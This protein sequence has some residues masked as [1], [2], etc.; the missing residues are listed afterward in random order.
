[1]RRIALALVLLAAIGCRPPA[2]AQEPPTAVVVFD[3]S[4]SMWGKP[5]PGEPKAKFVLA[6]EA[7]RQAF[8]PV[9]AEARLGLLSFGH[10]RPG[11]CSDVETIVKAESGT[12]ERIGAALDKLNPKGR[13]PITAALREAAKELGPQSAQSSIILVHDD[14]DNCQADP[15]SVVGELRRAHPKVAVHVVSIGLKREDAQ[16]MQCLTKPTG[17]THHEVAS[18]Q[19]ATA[20]IEGVVKAALLDRVR[21]PVAAARKAAPETE[22]ARVTPPTAPSDKSGL[23]LSVSLIEGGPFL[24]VPVRW[25]ITPADKPNAAPV[26]EATEAAPFVELPT[27]VY[28]LE[29]QYGFV[30]AR[31][32]IDYAS[33][34][35]R[36]FTLPLGAGTIRLATAG[37]GGQ[38]TA[39]TVTFA[40]TNMPNE[41]AAI[42]RGIAPEVALVPGPYAVTLTAGP[43]RIERH[44]TVTAG[45][46]V[47]VDPPLDLG[48]VE[49]QVL[50]AAGGTPADGAVITIFED[51]PDA[52]LG[53]REVLRSA[54]NGGAFALPAGTYSSTARLSGLETRD[55]FAVK[56]G[57]REQ[58]TMVL[59]IARLSVAAKLP[60]QLEASEPIAL[61]LERLDDA[62]DVT[63]TNRGTATFVVPAGRY[64]LEARTG[65]GSVR[66]ER[67]LD[68]RAGTREETTFEIPAGGLQ[69]RMVE[70]GKTTP[71]TDVSWEILDRGGRVIWLAHQTEARPILAPGRYTVRGELRGR[72]VTRDVEVRAGEI[73]P[74]EIPAP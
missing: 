25:R 24:D 40:R 18:A 60:G 21:E 32:K 46:R 71:V 63:H 12:A 66:V 67:E 41:N 42:L 72:Q 35:A 61:R 58:R 59:D 4:G 45:Q 50:A 65:Y 13:G 8:T 44:V 3:G 2:H 19:A 57:E 54:A 30:V 51:D 26:Y 27:G 7:L 23:Q 55:R 1:M 38:P 36:A 64:K 17:G 48:E 56:A 20:A 73:R 47:A 28:Q 70:A 31:T 34:A 15:C 14:L 9:P 39:A 53:R 74:L 69:L 52:P 43:T 62:K 68:L 33:P 6:R 11:D 10:R 22:P 29:A 5:D 16:K 37:N 49:I